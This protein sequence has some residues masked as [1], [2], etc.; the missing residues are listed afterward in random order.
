MVLQ[1]QFPLTHPSIFSTVL[2]SSF[3]FSASKFGAQTA[4]VQRCPSYC[5]CFLRRWIAGQVVII[6]KAR[7]FS[8]T[9]YFGLAFVN[10]L[11]RQAL[12][13]FPTLSRWLILLGSD[14]PPPLFPK[15][16]AFMYSCLV[17]FKACFGIRL[18]CSLPCYSIGFF[19]EWSTSK[20]H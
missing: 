1:W 12:C 14:Q 13:A 2:F 15:C 5:G 9:P 8:K 17:N 4:A 6:M 7:T 16:F 18:S 3:Q 20:R 10:V 19:A 11:T